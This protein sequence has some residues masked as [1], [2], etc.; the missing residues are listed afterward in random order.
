MLSLS[1]FGIFKASLLGIIGLRY[2]TTYSLNKP[3]FE[4]GDIVHVV[5][6]AFHHHLYLFALSA[7]ITMDCSDD[8]PAISSLP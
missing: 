3:D 6:P 5:K 7:E 2:W 8:F 1:L 4:G